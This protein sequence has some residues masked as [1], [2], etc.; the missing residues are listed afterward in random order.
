MDDW[1]I[2]FEYYVWDERFFAGVLTTLAVMV[3]LN[4]ALPW[5]VKNVA[6]IRQ[7]VQPPKKPPKQE[8]KALSPLQQAVG[9]VAAGVSLMAF[10]ALVA[11]IIYAFVNRG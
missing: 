6:V 4:M 7:F 5:V 10:G 11:A 9:C 3:V 8:E 2:F 1:Q